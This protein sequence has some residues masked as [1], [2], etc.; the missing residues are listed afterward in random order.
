MR[1]SRVPRVLRLRLYGLVFLAVLALLLSL[2]VAV[3]RQVFTPVVRI[4][5]EADS[6]GNQ[7][8]PRADV[9]LRGLLVGEVREVHADG[10]KATLSSR[11]SRSTS[12][13]SR[14]MSM[15]GCFPRR[16]SARST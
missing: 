16:C 11:S 1:A 12:R 3:Y 9:K 4:T 6:L 8:D 14:P 13:T 7:L 5:L 15:R 10:T 2:S